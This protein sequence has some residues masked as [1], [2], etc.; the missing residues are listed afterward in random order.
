MKVRELISRLE[1]YEELEA[2][3]VLQPDYP[4]VAR[5]NDVSIDPDTE[6]MYIFTANSH[7]YYDNPD[8]EDEDGF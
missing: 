3:V 5:I 6:R 1:G 2:E 8:D 7:D 4:L